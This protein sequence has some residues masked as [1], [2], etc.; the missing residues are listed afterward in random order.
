MNEFKYNDVDEYK[1][2]ELNDFIKLIMFFLLSSMD[3]L[4]GTQ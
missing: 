1:Y 2:S 3:R 4:P